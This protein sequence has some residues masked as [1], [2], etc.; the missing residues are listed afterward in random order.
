MA[1]QQGDGSEG[2]GEGGIGIGAARSRVAGTA[3]LALTCAPERK[4]KAAPRGG[5]LQDTRSEPRLAPAAAQEREAYET[6]A[7]EAKVG[8]RGLCVAAAA[9]ARGRLGIV[10]VLAFALA[11]AFAFAFAF[12]LAFALALAFTFALALAFTFAFA[13]GA[14]TLLA[15][16]LGSAICVVG[17]RSQEQAAAGERE[18][19]Q[20]E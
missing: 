19:G 20:H 12:A 16:L 14:E 5:P 15:A 3:A 10:V 18:Q 8:A 1:Q 17:A 11:F 9:A 13:R 6:E 4:S 7:Q 2:E